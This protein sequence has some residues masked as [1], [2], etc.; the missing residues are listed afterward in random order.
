LGCCN[1]TR[2][3]D[4]RVEDRFDVAALR[5]I[6]VAEEGD[7]TPRGGHLDPF[8]AQQLIAVSDDDERAAL[9]MKSLD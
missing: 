5:D 6:A 1:P 7:A 8:A 9:R 4:R 2:L 3:L